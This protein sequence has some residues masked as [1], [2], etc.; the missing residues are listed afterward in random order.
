MDI[1]RWLLCARE[2]CEES[3]GVSCVSLADTPSRLL[4]SEH[5]LSLRNAQNRITAPRQCLV[6]PGVRLRLQRGK[7]KRPTKMVCGAFFHLTLVS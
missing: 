4:L 1:R 5:S 6:V 3:D 2:E 7:P